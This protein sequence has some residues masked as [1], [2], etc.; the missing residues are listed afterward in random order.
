MLIPREFGNMRHVKEHD[1]WGLDLDK[2][3]LNENVGSKSLKTDSI[4][5]Q[6]SSKTSRRKKD[7]TKRHRQRH[8]Q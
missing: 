5:S 6:F 4:K 2:Y 7:R 3:S 8:H 1:V